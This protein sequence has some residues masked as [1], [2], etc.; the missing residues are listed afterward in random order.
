MMLI[1]LISRLLTYQKERN[2]PKDYINFFKNFR[3]FKEGGGE[4]VQN[5]IL[6]KERCLFSNLHSQ[7]LANKNKRIKSF[8]AKENQYLAKSLL[9]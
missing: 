7:K 4:L 6:N 2:P 9:I 8:L 1:F 5:I 3:I